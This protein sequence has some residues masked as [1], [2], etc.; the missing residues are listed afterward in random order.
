MLVVHALAGLNTAGVADFWRDVYWASAIA[1]GERF[2]LAGPPVHGLFELGPWWYCLLAVPAWLS[3]RASVIA[4]CGQLLAG[5]AYPFAW[6]LGTRAVDARFGLALAGALAA[7]GWSVLPIYFPTHTAVTMTMIVL[8]AAAMWRGWRQFS[9][10]NAIL[11]GLAAAGCV[12]AHPVTVLYIAMAGC[13]LLVRHRSRRALACMLLSAG[14]VIASLLPPWLDATP[15]GTGVSLP[16][17]DYLHHDVAVDA[18]PRLWML[19]KN[20]WLDGS[21]DGLLLMTP[22]RPAAARLGWIVACAG[23]ALA[24]TGVFRLPTRMRRMFVVAIAVFLAQVVFLILLRPVTPMWMGVSALPPIACATALGWYGWFQ[25]PHAL[26]GLAVCT[27]V[28]TLLLA[29]VPFGYFLRD[30]HSVRA[31]RGV[32][33]YWDMAEPA[34]AS[35]DV[36]PVPFVPARRLEAISATLCADAVLHGYLAVLV[37]QSLATTVRNACGRLPD[38]RFGGREGPANH[39]AGIAAAAAAASGIAPLREMDGVA[40]YAHVRPVAP[41]LGG[42]PRRLERMQVSAEAVVHA[43]RPIRLEFMARGDEVVV[44]LNRFRLVAPLHVLAVTAGGK[45]SALLFDNGVSRL[46]GCRACAPQ[47]VVTWQFELDGIEENLDLFTL[48]SPRAEVS[49]PG[50]LRDAGSA[51]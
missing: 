30:L 3:G 28:L 32:N 47:A 9:L 49:S 19:V 16:V 37:E 15:A 34:P 35:Y 33:P 39:L 23:I 29:L 31:P 22:W 8:L 13:A 24:M 42:R 38:L 20:L 10:G 4:M 5:C 27:F 40:F 26:R 41:A 18:W 50:G 36:V 17:S 2:P 43:A 21:W 12:N 45:P 51:L 48:E 6:R 25:R 1:H 46:Y 14:I 44:L 7:T 11:F